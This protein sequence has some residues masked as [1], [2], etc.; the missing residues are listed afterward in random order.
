VKVLILLACLLN[1]AEVKGQESIING[2]VTL[3]NSKTNTGTRTYISGAAVKDSL[4]RAQRTLTD[5]NGQFTLIYH[6]IGDEMPVGFEVIK[7]P[8]VVV[9]IDAL[10]AITGEKDTVKIGM[11]IQDSADAYRIRL[12]N[13]SKTQMDKNIEARLKKN[14]NELN[15][16]RTKNSQDAVKIKQLENEIKDLN[17]QMND[18]DKQ[19]RDFASK[20][21]RINLDDATPVFQQAFSL[22]Q[23]GKL[24]EARLVLSNSNPA[25]NVQNILNERDTI[26]SMRKEAAERDSA[27]K[28][29]TKDEGELLLLKIDLHK[30]AYEIDSVASCFGLLMK[31][32]SSNIDYLFSYAKFLSWL[33]QYDKAI[34]YYQKIL[35]T[36]QAR[37]KSN[38]KV[39]EPFIAK[40]QNNLGDL[41]LNKNDLDKARTALME[42]LKLRKHLAENNPDVYEP[43]LAKTLNNLGNLYYEK[44]DFDS[45]ESCYITAI[46]IRMHRVDADSAFNKAEIAGI[47]NNLGSTYYNKKNYDSAEINFRRSLEMREQ[48]VTNDSL[49]NEPEIAAIYNN[50]GNLY[51]K[52]GDFSKADSAYMNALTIREHL[53][54]LNQQTYDPDVGQAHYNLGSFYLSIKKIEN[55]K[56]EYMKCLNIRKRLAETDPQAFSPDLLR[57][58]V[59]LGD[60]YYISGNL[61]SALFFYLKALEIRKQFTNET[62]QIIEPEIAAALLN[63]GNIYKQQNNY[64]LADTLLNQSLNI[65]ERLTDVPKELYLQSM[66]KTLESLLR[67]YSDALNASTNETD[68]NYYQKKLDEVKGKLNELK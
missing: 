3:F 24:D 67:L 55:A 43:D 2:V 53:A 46:E 10:S 13:I 31:L 28:K 64:V 8:L 63:A 9:N 30:T 45:A 56:D 15:D 27:Q 60:V 41:Y 19:A 58:M 4:E 66:K 40:S 39:Y 34:F 6:G 35:D 52:K 18:V 54:E 38:P 23:E 16:L 62:Q 22:F 17:V 21:A 48:L 36:C 26:A 47:E 25:G 1:F 50:L 5:I 49:T 59:N 12:Y 68:K 57:V 7:A 33:N 65:R 37:L 44:N 51:S 20:Y 14:T 42:S 61:D 11:A 29:A 32:D